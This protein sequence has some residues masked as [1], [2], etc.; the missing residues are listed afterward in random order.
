VSGV[1]EATRRF[2]SLSSLTIVLPRVHPI[3]RL[4]TRPAPFLGFPDS[5]HSPLSARS[6]ETLTD[7]V[8][9]AEQA[10]ARER[11]L[12]KA[13]SRLVKEK[14]FDCKVEINAEQRKLKTE[15]ALLKSAE[16]EGCGKT[17]NALAQSDRRQH[18]AFSRAIS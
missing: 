7:L 9:R 11:E 5:G 1:N 2:L 16:K 15:L 17:E 12:D 14:Q 13:T 8:A 6:Q 4:P 3:L 10:R 18:R